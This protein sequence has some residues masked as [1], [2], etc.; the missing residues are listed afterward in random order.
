[1]LV[2]VLFQLSDD[3]EVETKHLAAA[4]W[5]RIAEVKEG[6][7]PRDFVKYMT[8]FAHNRVLE[9]DATNKDREPYIKENRR[10]VQLSELANH[11]KVGR[12]DHTFMTLA[13]C[14]S[15]DVVLAVRL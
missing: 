9:F 12:G 6:V 10:M 8:A 14:R 1:M 4:D 5:L 7:N 15:L 13:A 2:H 11:I 3:V